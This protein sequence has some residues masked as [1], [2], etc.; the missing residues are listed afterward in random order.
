MEN[1]TEAL[2]TACSRFPLF[3]DKGYRVTEADALAILEH[4]R[5]ESAFS[6]FDA[7]GSGNF[8]TALG[9]WNKLSLSKESSPIQLMAGLTYCFRKLS[10]W[11]RLA[12]S[13]SDT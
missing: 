10:D 11:H 8:E 2:K 12:A 9:I 3:F 5:E 1:N 4:N 7:M 6:L 13:A